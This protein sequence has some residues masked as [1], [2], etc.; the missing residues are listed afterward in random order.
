LSIIVFLRPIQ[1]LNKI[2]PFA[3]SLLSGLLISLAW[4]HVGSLSFLSFI[5]LVPFL[6]AEDFIFRKNYRPRRVFFNA[7]LFAFTFNLCTTWWIYYAS[8]GGMALAVIVNALFMATFLWL[9]HVTKR[10][11]GV[12]EGNIAFVIYWIAFE[13][14]HYHWELSWPWLNFGNV[15]ANEIHII[16]W[17]EYTGV[18]GGTL[19]ILL[20]NLGIY[21][22]LS[23]Y[24]YEKI[25]LLKQRGRIIYLSSLIIIP[26]IVSL[27]I[28][29]NF[30]E[31]G[32]PVDVVVVQPN[33]DPYNKFVGNNGMSYLEDF[34]R[35]AASKTDEKTA[36][37][38]GPETALTNL[39]NEEYL[40]EDE[41]V[42]Y[43]SSFIKHFPNV[44]Y[45]TGMFSYDP[46]KEE[47][48]NAGL[49]IDGNG[50]IQTYHKKWLVLGV[51]TIPFMDWLPFMKTLAMDMGGASGT[52][53]RQMDPSVFTSEINPEAVIAPV[54]CYESIYGEHITEFIQKGATLIFIMTN[55]GWWDDTPGHK[56][57]FAYARLRA[58]ETRRD[59]ARSANTGISGFINQRGEIL[60]QTN[61]WEKDVIKE[62]LRMNTELTAYVK[63]GDFIGRTSLFVS[64]M[65]IIYTIF[66]WIMGKKPGTKEV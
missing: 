52:L 36:F 13:Y 34:L 37:V 66:R 50:K 22:W 26:I 43:A 61:W 35:L 44:R 27:S 20:F 25:P 12:K 42:Q 10:R 47:M 24:H 30:E 6:W 41:Q 31:K 62:T 33:V 16:Q 57:H 45:V 46:K 2:P 39:I 9:F 48:Y 32:K 5:A 55:D 23:N 60:Q 38:V 29:N 40:P 14:C 53:G 56:Q 8:A 7:Y 63:M 4:P 15:F 11:I 21:K 19:W 65:L 54:I 17:Y 51:E 3:F 59:I 64:M 58:I 28:W 1:R 49:Q 18:A